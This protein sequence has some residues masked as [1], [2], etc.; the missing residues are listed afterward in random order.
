MHV[1]CT[2]YHL[3]GGKPPKDSVTLSPYKEQVCSSFSGSKSAREPVD[4]HSPTAAAGAPV[5]PC[6]NFF[7]KKRYTVYRAM[8]I[9]VIMYV[10]CTTAGKQ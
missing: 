5:K 7:F 6:L 4:S 9:N 8:M 2:Q 3:R 10:H 1:P